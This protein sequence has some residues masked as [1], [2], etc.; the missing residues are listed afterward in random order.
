MGSVP[1]GQASAGSC[2]LC[3]TQTGSEVT[4]PQ[5]QGWDGVWT[6][7]QARLQHPRSK[8]PR[9]HWGRARGLPHFS[10]REGKASGELTCPSSQAKEQK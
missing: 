1:C 8:P 10:E 5:Q 7:M 9:L 6:H 4:R 3:M 2:V